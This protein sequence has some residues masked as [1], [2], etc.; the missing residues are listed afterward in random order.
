M[1]TLQR[2]KT[3]LCPSKHGRRPHELNEWNGLRIACALILLCAVSAIAAHA[4]T[5]NTIFSFDSTHGSF[6]VAAL[7][8]G[9]DGNFYGTTLNG[10]SNNRGTVFMM[11][12]EGQVT[13]L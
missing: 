11:T 10:G 3:I 2:L 4:Q 12:P 7:M 6:P 13:T 1:T 5:L 8:Q 9:T